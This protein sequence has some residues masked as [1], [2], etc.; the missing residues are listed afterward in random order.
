M[1]GY[2]RDIQHEYYDFT[3]KV[4]DEY[5]TYGWDILGRQLYD[6]IDHYSKTGVVSLVA[7]DLRNMF[8]YPN[9]H[10][11]DMY[12][13]QKEGLLKKTNLCA[14]KLIEIASSENEEF[15]KVVTETKGTPFYDALMRGVSGYVREEYE[16]LQFM[17]ADNLVKNGYI[18]ENI[19]AYAETIQ[20]G[21]IRDVINDDK[22]GVTEYDTK[23][24]LSHFKEEVDFYNRLDTLVAERAEKMQ[25][26]GKSDVQTEQ[27]KAVSKG[28][29]KS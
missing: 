15:K 23:E 12:E 22:T 6:L 14:D 10:D 8:R 1:D 29:T 9:T 28:E 18:D 26:I 27:N 11:W 2:S 19:E 4:E 16:N 13:P 17:I 7:E 21:Y 3:E 5:E 20:D 25:T 24:E